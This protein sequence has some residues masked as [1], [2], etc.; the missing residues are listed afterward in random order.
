[1]NKVPIIN[2]VNESELSNRKFPETP[3][4]TQKRSH[5]CKNNAAIKGEE[6]N[7]NVCCT[8]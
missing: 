3:V 4:N 7:Q 8:K 5:S 2:P 6:V 1:M